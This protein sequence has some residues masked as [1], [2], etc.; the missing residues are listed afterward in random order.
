MKNGA[1]WLVDAKAKTDA[2]AKTFASK[3]SLSIEV[4][5]TPIFDSP[6]F[7]MVEFVPFRTRATR[8]LFRKLDESKTIG[9]DR[10][11]ASILKRPFSATTIFSL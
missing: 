4:V 3:S 7:P 5:D 11:S 1:D 6:D 9:Y 2:F 10:I 8:N